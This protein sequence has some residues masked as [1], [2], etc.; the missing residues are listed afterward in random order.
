MRRGVNNLDSPEPMTVSLG[1][2]VF[3]ENGGDGETVLRA[4]DAAL[5]K[6]KGLGGN[7]VVAAD[8]TPEEEND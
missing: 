5:Y 6:A 4:A 8:L 1:T 2:A 3:P 7:Q